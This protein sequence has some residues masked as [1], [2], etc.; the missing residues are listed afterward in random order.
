M[1]S[2]IYVVYGWKRIA[3]WTDEEGDDV[4]RRGCVDP[5][6]PLPKQYRQI[7]SLPV[8]ND[9]C[10]LNQSVHPPPIIVDVKAG[11]VGQVLRKAC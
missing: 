3:L 2:W 11:Q 6:Q 7:K 9:S 4:C 1:C 10:T 5:F 8:T